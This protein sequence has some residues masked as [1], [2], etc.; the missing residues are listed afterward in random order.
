MI[1]L[2]QAIKID[3]MFIKFDKATNKTSGT[4]TIKQLMTIYDE[5]KISFKVMVKYLKNTFF[6]LFSG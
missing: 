5:H 2:K 3:Q 6:M 4:L 1:P